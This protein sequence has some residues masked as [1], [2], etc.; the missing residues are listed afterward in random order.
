MFLGRKTYVSAT[1]NIENIEKKPPLYRGG[2]T[3]Y[4]G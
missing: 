3:F 4:Y 2:F 1:E